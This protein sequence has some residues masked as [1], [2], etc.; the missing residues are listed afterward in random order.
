MH[1]WLEAQ[2]VY[3][4]PSGYLQHSVPT[5]HGLTSHVMGLGGGVGGSKLHPAPWQEMFG[6]IAAVNNSKADTCA[7]GRESFTGL[8]QADPNTGPVS[9]NNDGPSR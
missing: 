3:Q 7:S 5:G 6:W 9:L 8:N 4:V 1:F 2:H